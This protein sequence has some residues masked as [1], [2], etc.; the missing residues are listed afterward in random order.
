MNLCYF[1]TFSSLLGALTF[2][3]F[4]LLMKT[5]TG[6][7]ILVTGSLCG[8]EVG[9]IFIMSRVFATTMPVAWHSLVNQFKLASCAK[10]TCVTG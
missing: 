2:A 3:V 7:T 1:V 4:C 8:I 5:D 6:I 10:K 9:C